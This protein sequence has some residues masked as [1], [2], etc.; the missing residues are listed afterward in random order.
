VIATGG[1]AVLDPVNVDTMRASG[2]TILL[3]ASLKQIEQRLRDNSSRPLV[4][5]NDALARI[6][7]TRRDIYAQSADSVVDTT[8]L[9]ATMA[10]EEVLKC[11]GT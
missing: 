10:A 3:T 6:Y 2:S 7:E 8:D 5:D 1:G 11:V 4:S 9:T